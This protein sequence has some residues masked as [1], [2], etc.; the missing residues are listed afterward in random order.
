MFEIIKVYT[1]SINPLKF[2]G[3]KYDNADRTDGTFEVASKWSEWFENGW[4][5]LIE[6]QITNNPDDTYED[7]G[8]YIGLLRNK[9][10]E[11]Y[12]YWIG[13]FVP[14]NT[15]TPKGFTH[16]NFPKSEIGVCWVYGKEEHISMNGSLDI[17]HQCKDR[18]EKDGTHHVHDKDN[19]CWAFERYTCPRFTT[20]DEKGNVILDICFFTK[21]HYDE[22]KKD[23]SLRGLA[24][25]SSLTVDTFLAMTHDEKEYC[26]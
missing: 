17:F 5:K 8:A 10:G 7:I 1:Q 25:D 16:I 24:A 26:D 9:S 18:L 4:F 13:M 19:V 20:P 23:C 2:I 21:F 15:E 22:R 11:Q 12:Q 14:E 6:K 3:K